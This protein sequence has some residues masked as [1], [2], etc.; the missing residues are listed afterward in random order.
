MFPLLF[1]QNPWVILGPHDAGAA[2]VL[3]SATWGVRQ[4][5]LQYG[6]Q[7]AAEVFETPAFE[8]IFRTG[9]QEMS[10]DRCKE[11]PKAGPPPRF[12]VT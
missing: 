11:V 6:K 3:H 7:S 9:G 10:R 2:S 4:H 5:A 1:L 12:P 8:D